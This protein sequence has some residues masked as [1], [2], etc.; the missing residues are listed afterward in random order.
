MSILG[1]LI[2]LHRVRQNITR[3]EFAL[4]VQLPYITVFKYEK[5]E[6]KSNV[7]RFFKILRIVEPALFHKFVKASNQESLE[8]IEIFLGIVN[9]KRGGQK[10]KPFCA[11][12]EFKYV[13]LIQFLRRANEPTEGGFLPIFAKL[14]PELYQELKLARTAADYEITEVMT[15]LSNHQIA[16]SRNKYALPGRERKAVKTFSTSSYSRAFMDNKIK[17]KVPSKVSDK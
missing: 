14:I 17:T 10:I 1:P 9:S 7:N 11:K 16:T 13:S 8:G 3:H 4:D 15:D 5:D 12:H 6:T 2:K